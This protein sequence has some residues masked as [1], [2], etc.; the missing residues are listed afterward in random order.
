MTTIEKPRVITGYCKRYDHKRC[1]GESCA[2]KCHGPVV[3]VGHIT[4]PPLAK[5][6]EVVSEAAANGHA[7]EAKEAKAV[8]APKPSAAP[9]KLGNAQ[10][11]SVRYWMAALLRDA[12]NDDQTAQGLSEQTGIEDMNLVVAYLEDHWLQYIDPDKDKARREAAAAARKGK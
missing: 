3:L 12:I 10:K 9:E 1:P 8:K 2:C 11:Q 6:H 4:N 7:I 5:L